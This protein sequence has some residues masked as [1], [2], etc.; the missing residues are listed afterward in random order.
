VISGFNSDI[1]FQGTIYHVQTEDKGLDTPVILSLVYSRGEILA[2]KRSPYDDMIA[3]GFDEAELNER[4]Q[5]QHKLIIAAIRAGRIDDL[6][7]MTMKESQK[8]RPSKAND[9]LLDIPLIDDSPQPEKPLEEKP[10]E[11]T[12]VVPAEIPRVEQPTD[13]PIISPSVNAA[14]ALPIPRPAQDLV[15]DI[16][17]S[18]LEE[19]IFDDVEVLEYG[20]FDEETILPAEAVK[21]ITDHVGSEEANDDRIKIRLLGRTTFYGGDNATLDIL[22]AQGG[23]LGK[24]VRG[25]HIAV[26]VLGSSF[27]PMIFHTRADDNGISQVHLQIPDFKSGRA[28]ILIKAQHQGEEIELRQVITRR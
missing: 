19:P 7:R 12:P 26:K 9:G 20:E 15:V 18:V 16:P 10:Q 28:A 5:R 6:K 24:G 25:A 22:V 27:R 8:R 21:I 17:I 1:E 14:D 11:E 3:A 13:L 2:S 4:L 23:K